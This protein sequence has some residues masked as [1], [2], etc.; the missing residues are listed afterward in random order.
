M[1]GYAVHLRVMKGE[2]AW[3]LNWSGLLTTNLVTLGSVGVEF[4]PRVVVPHRPTARK[5]LGRWV[6]AAPMSNRRCCRR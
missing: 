2:V 3:A 1:A 4:N 6:K 5:S